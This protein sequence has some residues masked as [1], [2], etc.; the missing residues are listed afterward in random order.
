MSNVEMMEK[1]Q[2]LIDD[3]INP[4]L[5][6][7][8]GLVE[9]VGVEDGVVAMRMAGGCQGCGAAQMTMAQGIELLIRGINH[10]AG[11]A[12]TLLLVVAVLLLIA[13]LLALHGLTPSGQTQSGQRHGYLI[14]ENLWARADGRVVLLDS[15]IHAAAAHAAFCSGFPI[16]P[17][18]YAPQSTLGRPRRSPGTSFAQYRALACWPTSP[19]ALGQK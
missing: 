9:L 13:A 11:T 8:G 6:M 7:H 5:A 18:P 12:H 14:P 10:A 15:G 3:T 19:A 2:T 1:L 17:S 4:A 16:P